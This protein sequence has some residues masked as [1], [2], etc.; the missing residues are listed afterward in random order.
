[1]WKIRQLAERLLAATN[2]L[3]L[4]GAGM[5][6]ACGI[7]DFRSASGIWNGPDGKRNQYLFSRNGFNN[8]QDEFFSAF[9]KMY[10]DF[11]NVINPGPY[12]LLKKIGDCGLCLTIATQNIDGL[13]K[14]FA[15]DNF[16][17]LELHGTAATMPCI[18]CG[19]CYT[20]EQVLRRYD[21]KTAPMTPCCNSRF[22]TDITLFG[23]ALPHVFDDL[24]QNIRK[25]DY[26]LVMGSSLEVSPVNLIPR[27]FSKAR[28]AIINRQSIVADREF[29]IVINMDIDECLRELI[30]EMNIIRQQTEDR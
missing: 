3:L 28:K 2:V 17:V 27:Y 5:S 9:K 29:D 4:S 23:D 26:L 14:R 13:H 8:E 25:F 16:N 20:T 7:P 6:T 19:K 10:T 22:D 18:A 1:M 30:A 12:E 15:S 21:G 11:A 24:L